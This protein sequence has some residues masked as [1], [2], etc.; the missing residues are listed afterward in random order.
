MMD[1]GYMGASKGNAY[2]YNY[3]SQNP[4]PNVYNG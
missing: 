2:T 1:T 4:G 3:G